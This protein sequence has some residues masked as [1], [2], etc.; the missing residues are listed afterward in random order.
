[1]YRS[2]PLSLSPSR[3]RSPSSSHSLVRWLAFSLALT[4]LHVQAE[5]QSLSAWQHSLRTAVHKIKVD[6]GVRVL[7]VSHNEIGLFLSLARSLARS[8]A[9][10][11]L[12]LHQVRTA[13]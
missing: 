7:A 6:I 11:R 13:S 2:L 10:T 8:L 3:T 1:M 4:G 12:R 5:R 9:L